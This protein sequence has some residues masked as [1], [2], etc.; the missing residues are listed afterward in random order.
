MK[1]EDK[2]IIT[3]DQGTQVKVEHCANVAV[4]DQSV[5]VSVAR[6]SKDRKV[7]ENVKM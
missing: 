4:L 7:K 3:T 2:G 1:I 5:S 6:S